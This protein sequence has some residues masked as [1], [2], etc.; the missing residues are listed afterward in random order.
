VL[1][2]GATAVGVPFENEGDEEKERKYPPDKVI[3]EFLHSW[4]LH[5][6]MSFEE[7][8]LF[9]GRNKGGPDEQNDG[10]GYD[11]Q[12]VEGVQSF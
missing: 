11:P 9:S 8:R 12:R 7:A 2:V 5:V 6:E 1:F 4:L 3:H 10:R